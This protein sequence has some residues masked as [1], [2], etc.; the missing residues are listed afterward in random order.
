MLSLVALLGAGSAAHESTFTCRHAPTALKIRAA[1]VAS[2]DI[3]SGIASQ[4]GR[5]VAKER[6]VVRPF[7]VPLMLLYWG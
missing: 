1:C 5:G 4:P 7:A 6:R 3:I 2:S